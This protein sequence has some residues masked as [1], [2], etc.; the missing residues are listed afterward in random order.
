[1]TSRRSHLLLL[2]L[3]VVT[4]GIHATWI[5]LDQDPPS[6]DEVRSLQ[7]LEAA[8]HRLDPLSVAGVLEVAVLGTPHP[9]GM[10]L[11]A[12]PLYAVCDRDF[13]CTRLVHVL[14]HLVGIIALY[15]LGRR[16]LTSTAGLTMATLAAVAPLAAQNTHRFLLDGPLAATFTVALLLA[17]ECRGFTRRWPSLL[18]GLTLGWMLLI[19]TTAI[20]FFIGPLL[21]A[22]I[23]GRGRQRLGG[24]I[25]AALGITIAIPWYAVNL[26]AILD[27]FAFHEDLGSIPPAW[28]PFADRFSSGALLFYLFSLFS[29]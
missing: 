18:F 22:A 29:P 24:L 13:T 8:T 27:L 20:A 1:M 2:L 4:G 21:I 25:L 19:R 23:E 17:L 6:H 26:G 28:Q 11:S 16:H 15:L 3:L 12:L 14:Y 10:P 7:W 5:H 9:P